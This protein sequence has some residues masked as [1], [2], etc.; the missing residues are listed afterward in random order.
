MARSPTLA[1]LMAAS[2]LSVLSLNMFLP[3]LAQIAQE[4]EVSFATASWAVSGYLAL[5]A[6]LQLILGPLSDRLG[7]RPIVLFGTVTFAA[8][9]VV[10]A[11]AQD[12]A[13]FLAA[14]L[15]QGVVIAGSTMAMASVRDTSE[16]AE[17][18]SRISWVAMGMAVGPMIAPMIGGVLDASFGWRSVFW[19]LS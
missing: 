7:R 4:F 8:L 12:F 9:S 6:G 14:R 19:F 15:F 1:T 18:A 3:S 11:L 16:P 13:T 17:A 5:T 2:A 10:C